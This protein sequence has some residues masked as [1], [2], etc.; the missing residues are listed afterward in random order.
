[1]TNSE[2]KKKPEYFDV[3]KFRKIFEQTQGR[4]A[5]RVV[6]LFR[7]VASYLDS[8]QGFFLALLGLPIL[9]G[10]VLAVVLSATLGVFGFLAVMGGIIGGVAFYAHRTVGKSMQFAEVNLTRRILAQFLAFLVFLG[11]LFF[12]IF[13]S[14]F[15]F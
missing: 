4:P 3:E 15:H 12:L 5:W 14:K 6:K 8:V 10:M 13:V 7:R 2:E 11:I 1:M 9:F